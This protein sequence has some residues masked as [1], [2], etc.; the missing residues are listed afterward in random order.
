M[1]SNSKDLKNSKFERILAGIESWIAYFR[2]NIHI[3]A[4][5]YLGIKLKTFQKIVLYEMNKCSNTVFIS[6]R[7][8]G[9]TF[10]TA[11]FSTCRAILYP[12][13]TIVVASKTR[14]QAKGV[15]DKINDIFLVESPLLK[16]EIAEIKLNQYDTEVKFVNGSKIFV[17]TANDNSRGYR[18]NIL[19]VD[20]Y[21]LVDPTVISTVLKKF[22]TAPRHCGFQDKPE[23]AD[24]I[25]E[26]NKEIYLSSAW[27]KASPAYET[28]KSCAAN[29]LSGRVSS[30]CCALPYQLAIKEKLLTEDRVLSDMLDKST[31]SEISW[32]MEMEALFWSGVDGALYQFDTIEPSRTI[33]YSFYPRSSGVRF[34]D[35]RMQIPPKLS[36]EKRILS[37]DLALMSSN[38]TNNDASSIFINQMLP[39]GKDDFTYNIV[40]T[41]NNEGMRSD[42]LALAIRRLFEEFECDYLVIDSRG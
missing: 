26:Q 29:M 12:G 18:A 8:I 6:S 11:L 17:C 30:F 22:L 15:I 25:P 24:Y 1:T 39:R 9:K 28:F 36:G 4:E 5:M 31:F 37:A 38:K 16:N 42:A 35:K 14:K 40:Y 3:F 27:Y 7:G 21:R 13:T 2:Q 20:E 33:K 10:L 41:E 23:Y 34:L 19:I 32:K